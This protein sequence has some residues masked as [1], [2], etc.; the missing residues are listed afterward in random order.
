M[1][2]P[3]EAF[4]GGSA[5]N[6]PEAD[7]GRESAGVEGEKNTISC[8]SCGADMYAD[9]NFC[10]SCGAPQGEKH[11]RKEGVSSEEDV[12]TQEQKSEQ[13]D[14]GPAKTHAEDIEDARNALQEAWP[15]S[16]VEW[17]RNSKKRVVETPASKGFL[18]FGGKE[19]TFKEVDVEVEMTPQKLQE[20]LSGTASRISSVI[21]RNI[22]DSVGRRIPLALS[23][24]LIR[25]EVGITQ[26]KMI[27]YPEVKEP[28]EGKLNDDNPDLEGS[29]RLI[30][31][32]AENLQ[33][34]YDPHKNAGLVRDLDYL[35]EDIEAIRQKRLEATEEQIVPPE[36]AAQVRADRG[37]LL[38]GIKE[39]RDRCE[40]RDKG[41]KDW[42]AR[43]LP[44]SFIDLADEL[45]RDETITDA[46]TFQHR[47]EKA[48]R[49]IDNLRRFYFGEKN[50]GQ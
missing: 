12:D 20:E 15:P 30:Q 35:S 10:G 3:S 28:I 1:V 9:S 43:R 18:G 33:K 32:T 40:D 42:A 34:A 5:D 29:I 41:I 21:N 17:V 38:E 16:P 31:G 2:N 26:A 14:V 49:I 4:P 6:N 47:R 19:A 24:E 23:D 11:E 48:D 22:Q 36:E 27:S 8:G 25:N 44:L 50:K 37:L 7:T 46:E 39:F 45:A 13:A